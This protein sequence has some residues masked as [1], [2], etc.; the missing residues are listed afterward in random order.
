MQKVIDPQKTTPAAHSLH[1]AMSTL[2]FDTSLQR[3]LLISSRRKS[4]M[5]SFRRMNFIITSR[6]VPKQLSLTH[7]CS[8]TEDCNG[9][10]LLP[11][12]IMQRQNFVAPQRCHPVSNC[13]KVIKYSTYDPK[14]LFYLLFINHPF[15]IGESAS[16]V[17]HRASTSK[18]CS[19]RWIQ[20]NLFQKQKFFQS[21]IKMLIIFCRVYLF[22]CHHCWPEVFI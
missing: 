9:S 12:N 20:S 10:L 21:I 7:T 4:R 11:W 1:R 5:R 17:L 3:S 16:V 14:L 18:R 15:Q 8:W 6:I 22:L 19:F 13:F 2:C